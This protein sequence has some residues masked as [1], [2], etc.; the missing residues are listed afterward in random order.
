[1]EIET[2]KVLE[3]L[4][5]IETRRDSLDR[6]IRSLESEKQDYL[7]E[8]M[9]GG[10]LSSEVKRIDQALRDRKILFSKTNEEIG[11][12]RGQLETRLARFRKQLVEQK[13]RELDRHL[14]RREGY[15]KRIKE[16]ELEASRYRYLVTG[17][18]DYR[19]ANVNNLLPSDIGDQ[20]DSVPIDEVIAKIKLEVSEINRMKSEVLLGDY[21]ARQAKEGQNA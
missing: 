18:K 6:E 14:R 11:N 9:K 4:K 12:L 2:E 21:L 10:R 8:V 16:L 20:D 3:R 5:E 19:L 17:I 13:Q 15:L 1:M 7:K